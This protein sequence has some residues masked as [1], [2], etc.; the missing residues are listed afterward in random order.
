MFTLN[1]FTKVACLGTQWSPLD[2]RRRLSCSFWIDEDVCDDLVP[3]PGPA[4]LCGDQRNRHPD[5]LLVRPR[6]GYRV[7][8]GYW[9]GLSDYIPCLKQ[10]N[11]SDVGD[12][13]WWIDVG[14]RWRVCSLPGVTRGEWGT[15][16]RVPGGSLPGFQSPRDHGGHEVYR[17]EVYVRHRLLLYIHRRCHRQL[18]RLHHTLQKQVRQIYN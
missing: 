14:D 18:N 3:A 17:G 2:A 12:K 6:S 5:Q 7:L 1:Y 9:L 15:P 4:T 10:W 8:P 13:R 16:E 11:Y